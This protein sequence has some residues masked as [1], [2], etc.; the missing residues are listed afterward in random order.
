MTT[1]KPEEQGNDGLV[2][3]RQNAIHSTTEIWSNVWHSIFLIKHNFLH[4]ICL[5]YRD[6]YFLKLQISSY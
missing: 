2:A 3:D 6:V 4:L 1:I 5:E